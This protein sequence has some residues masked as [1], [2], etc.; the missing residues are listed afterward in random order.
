MNLTS[1]LPSSLL[2]K[3]LILALVVSAAAGAASFATYRSVVTHQVDPL[4]KQIAQFEQQ[5][6][7]KATSVDNQSKDA[8]KDLADR[9]AEVNQAVASALEDY[10][11]AHGEQGTR[12]ASCGRV[13]AKPTVPGI[14]PPEGDPAPIPDTVEGYAVLSDD[15]LAT[16]QRILRQPKPVV[17]NNKGPLDDTLKRTQ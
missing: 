11:K 10:K 13:V 5:E 9:K 12:R 7:D 17:R 4:K 2:T 14:N 8:V 16:A 3:G 6:R 15:G 1:L